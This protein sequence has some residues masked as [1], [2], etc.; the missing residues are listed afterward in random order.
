MNGKI[1]YLQ[2]AFFEALHNNDDILAL[3]FSIHANVPQNAK[4]PY[5]AITSISIGKSDF[6]NSSKMNGQIEVTI[7]D[8]ETTSS[9]K[10]SQIVDIIQNILIIEKFSLNEI[11]IDN[12]EQNGVKFF[13]DTSI[14][15]A[16]AKC[17]FD[18]LFRIQIT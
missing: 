7:I 14:G 13:N 11:L 2:K 4:A 9:K 17:Y 10:I 16:W 12:I 3:G 6:I 18:V 5:I 15:A 8:K 1:W